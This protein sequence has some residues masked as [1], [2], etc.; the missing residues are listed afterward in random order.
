MNSAKE[1]SSAKLE[2]C[3]ANINVLLP[4]LWPKLRDKERWQVGKTYAEV[5]SAGMSTPMAALKQVLMKVQGFDYVPENLR[6]DTFIK[7]AE[8]VLKAH[9]GINNFYNE[10]RPTRN[11]AQLGTSIPIP[12]LPTCVTALLSVALGNRYGRS[13]DAAPIAIQ[14]LSQLTTNRWQYYL[15]QVLP[16]DSTILNK[17]AHDD[18]P[19]QTWIDDVGKKYLDGIEIKDI[20]V[21]NLITASITNKSHSVKRSAEKLLSMF[22]GRNK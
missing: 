18:L 5:Y 3:L 1:S 15:N 16:S 8:S 21:S 2:H 4:K 6:S 10:G 20:H 13:W 12:A 9:D 17:L 14:V 7:A 19:R 11:L 22:Y